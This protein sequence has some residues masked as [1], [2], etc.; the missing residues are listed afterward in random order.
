[1]N[2]I[3]YKVFLLVLMSYIAG[4]AQTGRI[5][6]R[7]VDRQTGEP[8]IGANVIIVGSS[9][10]AA[11]NINGEYTIN[12]VFAGIYTVK[13]SFIGYQDV[14][15]QNV[16]VNAGL[17]TRLNFE[18]SS[19]E[20]ATQ[21][22]VIVSQRP[23][24]E[25]TATN[26][27]RIVDFEQIEKIP[28][29]DLNTII[30]L[31]PGVVQ[32]NGLIFIRG[33]R[34]DETGY[35]VEGIDVKDVLNRRGGSIVTVIPDAV[36]ELSVQAGGYTAEFGN[37]NAGIVSSD[38]KTG[39]SQYKFSL[40]A[41]TDNFENYPGKK[42][43]GT[44]SYG[45]SDLV[46]T[47]S[48]PV[49]T[50]KLKFF[51]SLENAFQ[52]DNPR[53]FEGNPRAFSD[54]ALFDT[55]KVYDTGFFG[56]LTSDYQ[57]LKWNPANIPGNLSNRYT[58]NGTLLFDNNPLLLRLATVFSWSRNSQQQNDIRSIFNVSRIPQT[59]QSNVL[60]NLKGTY[61][62]SQKSFFEASVAFYD[63]RSKTYDPNFKD[64]FLL[65]SDS[66]AASRF[67]WV[68]SN[69]T[70]PPPPYDFYGFPFD[71]PGSDRL[72]FYSKDHNRY[73]SL[74]AAYTGQVGIHALKFGG[75]YQTWT[76]RRWRHTNTSNF[77]TT[78]RNNPDLARDS[79]ASL[80]GTTLFQDFD[81]YGFDVFGNETDE[82]GLFAPKKPVFASF[83][84]VDRIEVND[85]ILNAGLRYDYFNMDS[86][87]W[88]NPQLPIIDRE[89]HLIP[90]SAI[91]KSKA[92][93]YISPRLGFAFPITDRTVFHLQYGKFVQSPTLDF[94]Y[95]GVYQ[96]TRQLQGAN[97]FVN[98]V[99]YNPGPIRTTQY[100]IGFSHQ[101]TDFA[102]F[103]ITAFYK[104]I[105]GQ[106]QYAT[107]STLPGA[108]R[109]KYAV[110]QNQ[111]FATTKGIEFSLRIRRVERVSANLYYT[112]SNSLGTNSL[113]N[114]GLGSTEVNGNVP[115]VLTPLDYNQN[116]RG[117]I[118]IDYRFDEGDGGPILENSGVNLLFTFNSGH[119]YTLA[120]W[121]GLGQ[122]SAWTGGLTP[123]G[124]GDTRG[125]RP[126]GPINSSKTPWVY[127]IDVR[128][129][130][131]V[132]IFNAKFNFYVYVQNLLNTKNVLNVYDKT[133]NAY[134]DGFLDSPDGQ[135]IIAGARYTERFADLYR[136]LNYNNRQA[137][138][139]VYGYDL[140]GAPR[141][142]RFGVMIN[143]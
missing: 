78:V 132:K 119:P 64:E 141:Q 45:Y 60:I 70:T 71:R 79:L 85:L 38:F 109:S 18:L 72:T 120:Q 97:L 123:I 62:L 16:V 50:D 22:I 20:I 138:F 52:R 130:K 67:G 135:Q 4:M 96:A 30:A 24:I 99:A 31:Q 42:F 68:Y 49:V 115:T 88:T 6:G 92:Q 105:K 81:N 136:A 47:A 93:D 65:Y 103:D 14:T 25:K 7:V 63:F 37:A 143:Y 94:A 55:T 54:G 9:F 53:F 39:T 125:R 102:A 21:E 91:T 104:D 87:A 40:R 111:D 122:A 142:F 108:L 8:L 83:Y 58:A 33:S 77:L 11:T 128:I 107:I 19:K 5:S 100:E 84:F 133:G 121:T 17:T 134:N 113:S 74:N 26:A 69:Y 112:F 73:I 23:L 66:L 3:F 101:F 127:N 106:L 82:E 27:I 36:Q 1:M 34:P 28:T 35:L 131:T 10:G 59:D 2:K 117:S 46:L 90:D 95:R 51:F 124:S 44:Y 110:F 76:I 98:P 75:S 56:G 80:I 139:N 12:N 29:R 114:S 116:H 140:F 41:E 118:L 13:A 57:I 137:A 32:Q 43:L 61:V 129:D 48:G 15:V 89:T 86:W 126:V